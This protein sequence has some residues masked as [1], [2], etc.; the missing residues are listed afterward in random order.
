MIRRLHVPATAPEDVIRHLGSKERH[1]K[2]GRSAH[3]LVSLWFRTN[4]LPPNV[5]LAFESHP[6]FGSVELVDGFL[7][8]K[9]DLQ[10]RGRPSQTDL[11]VVA[12]LKNGIAIVGVEGK[13]GEPFGER[14]C[15]W[16]DGSDTKHDRL[17][18]LCDLLGLL[19]DSC[20]DLRYQL[21]HRTA[22]ILLEAKRYRCKDTVLLV[23]S[24]SN[25][26]SSFE[27][28]RMFLAALGF[29][30]VTIGTLI[31]PIERDDIRLYAAWVED[32]APIGKDPSD[33][34]LKLRAYSERIAEECRSI[35]DWCNARLESNETPERR[36]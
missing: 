8:R 4:D 29:D 15:E 11:L 3:A 36:G 32:T 13:A 20:E 34:L 7:E 22:S 21:L 10:S 31:G 1:W 16:N 18:A 14:V 25:D 23:H 5:K 28:F 35:K 9:V 2:E 27:D 33:Y 26:P 24:F 19:P 12:G 30:G 6:D 17:A